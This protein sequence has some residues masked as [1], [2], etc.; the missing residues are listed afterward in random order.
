MLLFIILASSKTLAF[1]MLILLL[2]KSSFDHGFSLAISITF[3]SFSHVMTKSAYFEAIIAV[4]PRPMHVSKT[5][6]LGEM[7]S[8][9]FFVSSI[10]VHCNKG[11]KI[12]GLCHY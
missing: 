11:F 2:P 1:K 8:I 6:P 9:F 10:G 3:S 7:L 4:Y 12:R 5:I